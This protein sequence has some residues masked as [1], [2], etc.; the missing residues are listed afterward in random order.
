M[1]LALHP[2]KNSI[3]PGETVDM[4]VKLE[5]I[6]KLRQNERALLSVPND[7][8]LWKDSGDVEAAERLIFTSEQGSFNTR[9]QMRADPDPLSSLDG[10][11]F[12]TRLVSSRSDIETKSRFSTDYR[13]IKVG[14]YIGRRGQEGK[15]GEGFVR[16]SRIR[17][18]QNPFR[19]AHGTSG[20]N[21]QNAPSLIAYVTRVKSFQHSDLVAVRLQGKARQLAIFHLNNGFLIKAK[22]GRG[23]DGG[24]GVRGKV[25]ADGVRGKPGGPG[26]N[27][28][29]GG[30]GGHGGNGGD[31][32]IYIDERYP[33]LRWAITADASGG[34]GG[35]G[36]AGGHAGPGG[37]A[38]NGPFTK[39]RG[40]SHPLSLKYHR[41]P[42][43]KPG[44]QGRPGTP[45]RDG[46]SGN[47]EFIP[48]NVDSVF[49]DLVDADGLTWK[50]QNSGSP[51]PGT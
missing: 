2:P 47:V 35:E 34:R 15:N 33:E 23:G 18:E 32:T 50:P 13:C 7:S 38:G 25:G 11:F 9:G 45:G 48:I 10:F 24:R 22:G 1:N 44:I 43:G 46:R 14:G 40:F 20:G 29:N 49:I 12:K 39:A 36:G 16:S 42:A 5:A 37:R 30:D 3:C 26:G 17:G 31:I 19:G 8:D 27:G 41:A 4:Q 51:E 6:H 28:G 21:G